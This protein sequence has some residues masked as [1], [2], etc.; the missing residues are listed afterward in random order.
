MQ[1]TVPVHIVAGFLGAGK[2][3]A[4]RAQLDARRGERVAVIVN[5]FGE[6]SFDEVSLAEGEPFRITNI[7]GGCVCCTAP[8]GFVAARANGCR[9]GRARKRS[10]SHRPW[11]RSCSV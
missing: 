3:T 1:H 7:P 5:D 8:E 10:G 2:T 6:A 11:I 9:T 4:I